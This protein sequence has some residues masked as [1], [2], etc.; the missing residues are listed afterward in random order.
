[1]VTLVPGNEWLQHVKHVNITS[2]DVKDTYTNVSSQL[3]SQ[4][5]E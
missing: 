1:M 4:L 5:S 2:H 3:N